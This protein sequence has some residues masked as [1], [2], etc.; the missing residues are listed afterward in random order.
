MTDRGDEVGGVVVDRIRRRR[1]VRRRRTSRRSRQSPGPSRRTRAQ[2]ES[3]SCRCRSCRRGSG[4]VSPRAQAAALEEIRP[5]REERLRNR[6]RFDVAEALGNGQALLHAAP[7]RTPRSRRRPRARRRDPR[8]AASGVTRRRPRPCRRP[9]GPGCRTPRRRRVLA[10]P[11]HDVGSI[12]AR[13]RPRAAGPHRRR[14]GGTARRTG[15][16]T[17]GSPGSAISM[18]SIEVG[19]GLHDPPGAIGLECFRR[20]IV[21][22][23]P[24]AQAVEIGKQ[25]TFVDVGLIE[26]VA[27]LPLEMRRDDDAPTELGS[28][29]QPAIH[30]GGRARHQRKQ[31]ELVEDAAIDRRRLEEDQE[32]LTRQRVERRAAS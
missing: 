17:L 2:V 30:V 9:R 18:A 8:S 7:R 19:S 21:A 15:R 11:L 10:Q 27:D 23:Q 32:R 25:N 3:R 6:G 16:R 4:R 29:P 13:P 31:R 12:D 5:H 26:L 28:L 24:A 1:V 20:Q 22:R 14:A